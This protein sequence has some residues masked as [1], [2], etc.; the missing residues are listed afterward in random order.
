MSSESMRACSA[1][2][3]ILACDPSGKGGC[4]GTDDTHTTGSHTPGYATEVVVQVV[5]PDS[6]PVANA[7]VMLGGTSSYEWVWTD[8]DG[9]AVLPLPVGASSDYVF[10][11]K[12]GFFS[13]GFR[14]SATDSGVSATLVLD[15]LPGHDN[16]DYNF[17][18]GGNGSSPDTSECGHCHWTIGDDWAGSTHAA[19]ATSPWLWDLYTGSSATLV[20]VEACETEGGS[21]LDGQEAGVPGGVVGRCYVGAGVLPWLHDNCGGTGQAACDHPDTTRE[22]FG[23]CGDCHSPAIDGATPGQLDLALATGVAREGVT[24]DLCHKVASVTPGPEAGLDGGLHLLRPSAPSL[25]LGH[26]FDPV[27]FGPYPDVVVPIMNGSYTPQFREAAWCASCHEYAQPAL[28]PDQDLGTRWPEGL[29]ILETWTEYQVSPYVGGATC[30]SCH[31]P[32]LDEESSTYN[33]SSVGLEP[34]IAN[35]WVRQIGEVRHHSFSTEGL[36]PP[37]LSVLAET[38]DGEV[39]ATVV[40]DNLSAGHAVPTGEPLRQLVVRVRAVAGDGGAVP[41][42]GG[43][44]VP[45]V[46]GRVAEGVLGADLLLEGDRLTL[47]EPIEAPLPLQVRVARPTGSWDDYGGPGTTPFGDDSLSPE[48]KGLPLSSYVAEVEV[49]R[50][51]G[52]TL[53]LSRTLD[54]ARDGDGVVVTG[55]DDHAGASGWLYAKILVDAEGELGVAHY[56]AVDVMSDNRIGPGGT[57]TSEHRFPMPGPGDSLEITATLIHR[58][59]AAPV[60]QHYGWDSGDVEVATG[61]IL[62]TD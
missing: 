22:R 61:S 42:T 48:E 23:S 27:T 59:R 45:G 3:F 6:E 18:K 15:P 62:I 46:G 21:W 29:P 11:A 4:G 2:L 10:A 50:V 55:T 57:G 19:A 24:C 20:T 30:Q 47:A 56:R 39:V 33:I 51:E 34:S 13:T 60:A 38:V 5:D 49:L 28:H 9:L 32:P 16:L 7:A 41:P 35:G 52:D 54:E 26:E 37:A 12:E 40:V 17:Q 31:M 8:G 25:L 44:V 14:L 1:L 58:A 43:Q 53:V 36:S